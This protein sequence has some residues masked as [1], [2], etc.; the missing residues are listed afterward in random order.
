MKPSRFPLHFVRFG[1][2]ALGASA[3]LVVAQS[4]GPPAFAP[5]FAVANS[6]QQQEMAGRLIADAQTSFGRVRDYSGLFYR[7]ERVNGQMQPEQTIQL[8]VRQQPFSVHMKWLGPQKLIGQE[9]YYVAGK[10]N[11]QVKVKGAGA[12][13]GAVGFLSFDPKD[14]KIMSTNRHPITEAGIGNLIDQL[15]QGHE[16]EKRQSPDQS[17]L[18]FAEF[19]FLNRPVTK[20]ESA[21]RTNNGQF[22]CHRTVVFIDKDTKLPVRF[23]AY[24]WPRQG[25]TPNGDMLE[26]YSFVDVKFNLGLNDSAFSH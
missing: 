1:S 9:A 8:R 6:N 12:L 15:V 18:S 20:M 23:E 17:V 3:A 10:N 11:N 26:C 5:T 19:K 13:L 7:Q 14:P 16:S 21:H 24:D 25:G 2:I 22:Y 4:P